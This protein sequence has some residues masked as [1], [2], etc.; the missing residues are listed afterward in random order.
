MCIIV[1]KP[2]NT[3]MP[4][5]ETLM[6]CF[7]SNPDGAGFMWADG[8]SVNIRKGFMEWEDFIEALDE[9]IPEYRRKETALVMHFRIAT[10]GKV[11]PMCCHPFPISSKLEDLQ[12]TECR[13]RFGVAHNGVIQGRTTND[14]RS[15][16]MD[17][18]VKVMAPLM[19]MNPGFMH[20][21]HALDLLEGACGSKLA[22]LDN[23]GELVTIGAFIEQDGV[24]YSNTSYLPVMSRYSSYASLFDACDTGYYGDAGYGE[25]DSLIE[26]LPYRACKLCDNAANC[27]YWQPEC[28]SEREAEEASDYYSEEEWEEWE[29]RNDYLVALDD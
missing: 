18:I 8:K 15:D 25:L 20:N 24:L 3:D 11:Q 23:S 14:K 2:S 16:T 4:S 21:D 12:K 28:K 10:H 1:A 19:K 7:L 17:F 26:A 22:I 27:V 5:E 9:E 29:K 6:N 13:A